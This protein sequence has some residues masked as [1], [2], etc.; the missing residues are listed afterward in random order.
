[1]SPVCERVV[2]MATLAGASS[3][4]KLRVLGSVAMATEE[5]GARQVGV[6]GGLSLFSTNTLMGP[7]L[8]FRCMQNLPFF[9]KN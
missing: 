8:L 5:D 4:D 1:M 2:D 9:C 6:A 3:A 7:A